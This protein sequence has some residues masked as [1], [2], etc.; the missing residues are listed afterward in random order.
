MRR[1]RE[2]RIL[3]CADTHLGFDEPVR[4]R[5]ERRR[6]GADFFANFERVLDHARDHRVDLVVHGGDLFFRSRVPAAIVD[7]VYRMLVRFAAYDIPIVIVP[8]NH[9]RS[10]LPSSIY[11]SHPNIHVFTQPETR[12][13]KFGETRIA[14]AGFPS[15]RDELRRRFRSLVVETGW[16]DVEADV[17]F[18]CLHQAIEGAQVG[19]SDFTF[20]RGDDVVP[21]ADLPHAFDAVL[22]GHIHRRQIL[23]HRRPDGS[24]MPVVYPGA[25]ERTSFAEKDEP[26]GY[27]DLTV[28]DTTAGGRRCLDFEFVPLFTRPMEEILLGNDVDRDNVR[29]FLRSNMARLDTNAIVRLR[30]TDD[31]PFGVRIAVT[32]KMLREVC[33]AKMNVQFGAGFFGTQRR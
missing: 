20:R 32:S 17:R 27:F 22:A 21:I 29:D 8:G 25:I 9:E 4:P 11:L 7:R 14:V 23:H 24:E 12:I 13:F 30:C 33:P 31:V 18:L 16:A 28:G 10:V 1:D 5:V 19:P 3:L 6:R 2:V 15:V 26:K